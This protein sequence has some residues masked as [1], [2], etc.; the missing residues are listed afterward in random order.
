LGAGGAG[1]NAIMQYLG[2]EMRDKLGVEMTQEDQAQW[3]V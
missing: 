3:D 2:D 1:K